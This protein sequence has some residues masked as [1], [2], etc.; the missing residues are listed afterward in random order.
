[1]QELTGKAGA[2]NAFAGSYALFASGYAAHELPVPDILGPRV[3]SLPDDAAFFKSWS[4][5]LTT[6]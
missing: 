1:M 2:Q 3:V 4:A 6:T 5:L